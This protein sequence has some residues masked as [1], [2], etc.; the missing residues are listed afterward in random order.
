MK[1]VFWQTGVTIL[2]L[3]LVAIVFAGCPRKP[4]AG[5]GAGAGVEGA[6]GAAGAGA[7]AGGAADAGGAGGVGAASPGQ[8][9]EG[10]GAGGRGGSVAAT[11]PGSIPGV[12]VSPREFIETTAL[13][14]VHFEYDKADIRPEGAKLL[15][16]NAKWLKS[17]ARA[18]IL[19][20][21]HADERGTNEYNLA[22]GE[23]RA[24][25]TRDYLVSLGVEAARISIISYGEERPACKESGE[26]CWLRNRRAH[27]LTKQ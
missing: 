15:E 1:K 21:G 22:L 10:A 27:F 18:Q 11:P 25:A 26:N 19:V 13:R 9:G 24:K 5:A 23:R 3:L 8:V 20:E 4:G 7:A 2:S 12:Q 17:N 14:D 16:E 6:A